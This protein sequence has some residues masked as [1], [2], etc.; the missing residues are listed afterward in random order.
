MNTNSNNKQTS[1]VQEE[2]TNKRIIYE[3]DE[4]K[5]EWEKV[6]IEEIKS[7]L[8]FQNLPKIEEIKQ[9]LGAPSKISEENLIPMNINTLFDQNEDNSLNDKDKLLN[10]DLNIDQEIEKLRKNIIDP[11]TPL[12][13]NNNSNYNSNS[14]IIN[15]DFLKEGV[16]L[17]PFFTQ[18]VNEKQQDDDEEIDMPS[19][20]A[21]LTLFNKTLST[22]NKTKN[23]LEDLSNTPH[24][25]INNLD[26]NKNHSNNSNTPNS[27]NNHNYINNLN[28][29]LCFNNLQVVNKRSEIEGKSLQ[30]LTSTNRNMNK[31]NISANTL[32]S[33]LM[34]NTNDNILNQQTQSC[35]SNVFNN[36][37]RQNNMM[38]MTPKQS[39]FQ[40]SHPS[41]PSSQF[42]NNNIRKM[43]NFENPIQLIIKNINI[44]GWRI[45]DNDNS[46]KTFNSLELLSFLEIEIN[47]GRNINNYCITDFELDI[48]FIPNF[49]FECLK[50]NIQL[51]KEKMNLN[52]NFR[53]PLFISNNQCQPARKNFT[54]KYSNLENFSTSSTQGSQP[55][56]ILNKM[57][58]H[59]HAV[60]INNINKFNNLPLSNRNLIHNNM[61]DPNIFMKN[62]TPMM[63]NLMQPQ[64][65][66]NGSISPINT[67]PN[68]LMVENQLGSNLRNKFPYNMM[69]PY[70]L[71][72]SNNINDQIKSNFP[73]NQLRPMN[74]NFNVNFVNNE[75]SLNN[76]I[77]NS[78]EKNEQ[79]QMPFFSPDNKKSIL[80]GLYFNNLN[81]NSEKSPEFFQRQIEKSTPLKNMKNKY[82]PAYEK[83]KVITPNFENKN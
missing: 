53:P 18:K 20:F 7:E 66:L 17:K 78:E 44:K 79:I 10:E 36:Y 32:K 37:P 42:H 8:K 72:Q 5:I 45:V 23:N 46:I 30:N 49:L 57:Y 2:F 39:D 40:N 50:E 81:E 55:P 59:D 21:D 16:N 29:Q 52:R 11:N 65:N 75:L 3:N 67:H 77:L 33:G 19:L 48:H 27:I 63:I 12:V 62:N 1:N 15:N 61:Q 43:L 82:T 38:T 58:S 22:P 4:E 9:S 69:P 28:Q 41:T 70:N 54:N 6:N 64:Y 14:D 60:S 25:F 83:S 26:E 56:L 74:F 24:I 51:I 13:L 34:V 73:V 31:F 80:N 68:D 76:I 71:P 47:E 35:I